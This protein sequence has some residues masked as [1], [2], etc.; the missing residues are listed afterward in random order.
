MRRDQ[1][2]EQILTRPPL[3]VFEILSPEDTIRRMTRKLGDYMAMGIS[4]IHV[5]DPDGPVY[6]RFQNGEQRLAAEFGAPGEPIHFPFSA[7]AALLD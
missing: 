4:H 1:P 2:I 3:A 6:Y 7:I 5:I